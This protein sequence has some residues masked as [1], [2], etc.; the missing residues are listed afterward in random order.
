MSSER[1]TLFQDAV[2]HAAAWI[3]DIVEELGDD[4][5]QVAYHLLCATLRSLRDRLPLTDAVHLAAQLPVLIRGLYYDGWR[6]RAAPRPIRDAPGFL[7]DIAARYH[8][9]PLVDLEPGVRAVL[10]VVGRHLDFGEVCSLLHALPDEL[11]ALWPA[12]LVRAAAAIP[13]RVRPGRHAGRGPRSYRRTDA[14]IA[15]DLCE[16]LLH[17]PDIDASEVEVAVEAGAV[18]LTGVVDDPHIKR[19][20]E[21]LAAAVPGVREVV[22]R[23]RVHPER[24]A[25]RPRRGLDTMQH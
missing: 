24:S 5:E 17:D 20:V 6:P 16:R 22:D 19:M 3:R 23:L 21:S 18:T 7:T 13:R 8:A 14:R 25:Y 12:H 15:E 2:R 10:T 9:R 4:D 11:H 1:F